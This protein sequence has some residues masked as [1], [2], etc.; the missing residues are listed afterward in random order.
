[1][2]SKDSTLKIELPE[3]ITSTPSILQ[4]PQSDSILNPANRKFLESQGKQE[5][6]NH[7]GS[8]RL[9]IGT[10]SYKLDLDGDPLAVPKTPSPTATTPVQTD[11]EMDK[12]LLSN[13]NN[14]SDS[15]LNFKRRFLKRQSCVSDTALDKDMGHENSSMTDLSSE[16]SSSTTTLVGTVINATNE[17]AANYTTNVWTH[18]SDLSS[19]KRNA[20]SQT[21]NQSAQSYTNETVEAAFAVAIQSLR[22]SLEFYRHQSLKLAELSAQKYKQSSN[23][24]TEEDLNSLSKINQLRDSIHQE[25]LDMD[26]LLNE[27]LNDLKTTNVLEKSFVSQAKIFTEAVKKV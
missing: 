13:N 21:D 14:E 27:H 9:I 3:I 18:D 25:L 16:L 6:V 4:S 22:L 15:S 24:F 12:E 8:K 11:N 2:S 1:L 5:E 26:S 10:K 23:D 20:F 19:D 7:L 17:S